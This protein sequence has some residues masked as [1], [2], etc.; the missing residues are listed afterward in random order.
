MIFSVAIVLSTLLLPSPVERMLEEAGF[1][2]ATSPHMRNNV[3]RKAHIRW[4]IQSLEGDGSGEDVFR[5]IDGLSARRPSDPGAIRPESGIPLGRQLRYNASPRMIQFHARSATRY[6]NTDFGL[7][8]SR[9]TGGLPASPPQLP[10]DR[11]L[12]EAITRWLLATATAES[13]TRENWIY[14]GQTYAALRESG[15]A[16]H[17]PARVFAQR[18]GMAFNWNEGAG[19]LSISSPRGAVLI[20]LG[21]PSVKV[22]SEWVAIAGIV[23]A[24]GVE[25]MLPVEVVSRIDP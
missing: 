15:A 19:R 12:L 24:D 9:S 16:K 2:K 22:G 11:P 17:V 25:P 8:S 13:M 14:H 1:T 3:S 20:V 18:R 4:S 23:V 7:G 5:S 21:A 6:V 10:S